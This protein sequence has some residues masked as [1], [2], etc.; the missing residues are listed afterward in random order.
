MKSA[1]NS[2]F[3]ASG[4]RRNPTSGELATGLPCGPLDQELFNEI[5]YRVTQSGREI[6]EVIL[7]A[8]ITLDQDD[9]SQLKQAILALIADAIGGV[10]PE[11]G[12]VHFGVDTGGAANT[13]IVDC[14]PNITAYA[15]GDVLF[16]IPDHDSTGASTINVDSNGVVALKRADGATALG[17]GDLV[18]G[19]VAIAIYRSGLFRLLYSAATVQNPA[20]VN[21]SYS[22]LVIATTGS[23]GISVAADELVLNGP[24]GVSAKVS[25]FTASINTATSGA[26]GIDAGTV[27]PNTN[28][29]IYAGLNTATGGKTAWLTIE[30]T[31]PAVPSGVTAY[32]RVGWAR[33]NGS[34]NLVPFR[35]AND[36]FAYKEQAGGTP[37]PVL[38]SGAIGSIGAGAVTAISFSGL[39]AAKAISVD[40]ILTATSGSSNETQLHPSPNYP[41]VTWWT[42]GLRQTMTFEAP[43]TG[44]IVAEANALSYVSGFRLSI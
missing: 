1:P 16:F 39:V 43:L 41:P 27:A 34:S 23:A 21:G 4:P 10:V 37:L 25:A 40:V 7:E 5:F 31:P 42:Q 8:G 2:S 38:A 15:D 26:G 9:L 33:T 44:Y 13:Y 18:A 24:G 28:W 3:G 11:V 6:T 12:M 14:A 32:K 29:E 22:E 30:G 36:L 35:Q 17:A 20:P 19:K